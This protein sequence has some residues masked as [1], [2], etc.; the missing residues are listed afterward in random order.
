MAWI[1]AWPDGNAMGRGTDQWLTNGGAAQAGFA[2][3]MDCAAHSNF[4]TTKL[5]SGGS[6]GMDNSVLTF[7]DCKFEK[8]AKFSEAMASARKW[9]AYQKEQGS[10]GTE[11]FFFPIYGSDPDWHFKQVIAY[12]NY[13]ALGADYERYGSGG[14]YMKAQEMLGD[15]YDCGVARVYNAKR[16]RSGMVPK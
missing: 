13:T 9:N 16:V 2:K 14:G 1:G 10:A 7:A 15:A 11:W 5:R 8:G 3:V 6:E 12:N 4:A